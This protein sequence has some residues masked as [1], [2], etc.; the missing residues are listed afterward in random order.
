MKREMEPPSDGSALDGSAP[1]R[2]KWD[3][4]DPSAHVGTGALLRHALLER[5]FL[6]Q[7]LF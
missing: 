7:A 4:V 3:V 1:R 5:R 2:S 6:L